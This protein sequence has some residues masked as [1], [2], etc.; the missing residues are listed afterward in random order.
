M[1]KKIQLP[2]RFLMIIFIFFI[3]HAFSITFAFGERIKGAIDVPFETGFFSDDP[4]DESKA[5]A[6]KKAKE[7]VWKE[8]TAGFRSSKANAYLKVK[9]QVLENLDDYFV[10]FKSPAMKVQKDSN[11]LRV[12]YRGEI[13]AAAFQALLDSVAP[14]K[15]SGEGSLFSFIFVARQTAEEKSFDTRRTTV[16]KSELMNAAD[17]SAQTDGGSSATSSSQTSASK[18]TTGGSQVKKA[19]K[20]KYIIKPSI[21]VDTTMGETLSTAGF[22]VVTFD[23]VVSECGGPEKPQ[24]E[25]EYVDKANMSRATRKAAIKGAKECEVKFFAVG[26]MDQQMRN[27][28]PN[29]SIRV[30]V[31]TTARVWNIEKRLPKTVVSINIP[32]IAGFGKDD[33]EAYLNALKQSAKEAA[34]VIV[35]TLNQKGLN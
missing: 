17:E 30:A 9:K 2:S 15:A 16:Q 11:T 18:M 24:I 20:R 3:F 33:E 4:D 5:K 13:N 27:V 32:P 25:E 23:D 7:A 19:T 10:S 6:L 22:E 29:G 12:A 28:A 21:D 26:T 8:Y 35:D 14:A 34:T 1:N 31:K